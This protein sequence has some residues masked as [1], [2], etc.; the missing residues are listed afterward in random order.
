M[1]RYVT[2]P[3]HTA[4]MQAKP[5]RCARSVREKLS[6]AIRE[7]GFAGEPITLEAFQQRGFSEAVVERHGPAA[8]A[9]ARRR[10]VRQTA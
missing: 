9:H 1:I 5:R 6:D 7:I 3:D 10:S 2:R 8:L 4:V